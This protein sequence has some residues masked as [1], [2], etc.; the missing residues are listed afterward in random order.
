M[1]IISI[2]TVKGVVITN[3]E[4]KRELMQKMTDTF[5]SVVGEVARPFVYCVI[6]EVPMYEM[7][8]AGRPLPDLAWLIGPDFTAI[9]ERSNEIM[10]NYLEQHPE[11]RTPGWMQGGDAGGREQIDQDRG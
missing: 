11:A 9:R 4:Q 2:K 10:A 6:E 3:D 1:P 5:I 7:S 8:L